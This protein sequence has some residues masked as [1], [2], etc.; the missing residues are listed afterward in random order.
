[1]PRPNKEQIKALKSLESFPELLNEYNRAKKES[2][3][4]VK[5]KLAQR[6]ENWQQVT[7]ALEKDPKHDTPL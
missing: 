7:N 4:C 3:D 1:M 2:E 5:Q 6:P